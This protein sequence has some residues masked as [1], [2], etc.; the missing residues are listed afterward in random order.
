MNPA[1]PGLSIQIMSQD[2][3][4]GDFLIFQV[5]AGYGLLRLLSID[6]V[7]GEKVW[8][9]AAYED[10]FLDVDM[11]DSAIAEVRSL[12]VSQPHLALTTRAFE[13]TQTARMGNLPL[14]DE[15]LMPLKTWHDSEKS[16]VSDLSVRLHLGLR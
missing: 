13:A 11:A 12:K 14:T 16:E 7:D 6:D 10:L 9:V 3:Q 15:E 1:P 8:H 2:F 4:S 5:E